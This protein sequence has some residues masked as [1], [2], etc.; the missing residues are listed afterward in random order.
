M[1]FAFRETSRC[2][3]S[4]HFRRDLVVTPRETDVS[5]GNSLVS[6]WTFISVSLRD[7]L[8]DPTYRHTGTMGGRW[9]ILQSALMVCVV[10]HTRQHCGKV[11]V[12]LR[13]LIVKAAA[14]P[15]AEMTKRFHHVSK[16]ETVLRK[17][18]PWWSAIPSR[19]TWDR[20]AIL[21]RLPS[22]A[23]KHCVHKLSINQTNIDS[24][25]RTINQCIIA[26]RIKR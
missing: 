22:V 15:F 7:A 13:R 18:Q 14:P 20:K 26:Q 19:S 25:K 16:W 4:H 17:E 6:Q 23:Y 5:K 2:A 1:H 12:V 10:Y 24:F 8:I 21:F 11:E 3:H 9:P